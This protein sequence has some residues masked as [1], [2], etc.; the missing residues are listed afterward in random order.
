MLSAV[1]CFR[2]SYRKRRRGVSLRMSEPS[3]ARSI[4]CQC[5]SIPKFAS[6]VA[7]I[8]CELRNRSSGG[9]TLQE[10]VPMTR[11]RRSLLFMPGSN[12]RALEKA[13]NLPADGFILDLEDS[14]AP[15]AKARAREQIAQALAGKGFGRREILI[16]INGLDTPWWRE[17]VAF[18]AHARPDGI[19]VPKVTSVADLDN[20]A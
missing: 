5:P 11:P 3:R 15:D 2:Y 9:P 12:A 13:P 16:R 17:D 20:V 4:S 1:S 8:A 7:P 18:A 19:L 6:E 14:V 10:A